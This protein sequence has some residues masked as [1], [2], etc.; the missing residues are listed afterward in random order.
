MGWVCTALAVPGT[1]CLTP[2]RS[3]AVDG[4][5]GALAEIEIRKGARR[6]KPVIA[7]C[8]PDPH[9]I[10]GAACTVGN[11][12]PQDRVVRLFKVRL[13]PGRHRR[14]RVCVARIVSEVPLLAGI[15]CHVEQFICGDCLP[16][17]GLNLPEAVADAAESLQPRG[18]DRVGYVVEVSYQLVL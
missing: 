16:V 5:E 13:Q 17:A 1:A 10:R 7:V 15:L 2:W 4:R 12:A 14:Q 8:C 18:V 3:L 11:E 6:V 9:R